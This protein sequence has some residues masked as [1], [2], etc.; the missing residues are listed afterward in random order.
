MSDSKHDTQMLI[1]YEKTCLNTSLTVFRLPD[2]PQRCGIVFLH[3]AY[4]PSDMSPRFAFAF[5]PNLF[6]FLLYC[7]CAHPYPFSSHAH[8]L[9]SHLTHISS[10]HSSPYSFPLFFSLFSRTSP[11]P[12][13]SSL[14]PPSSIRFTI[15]CA[16]RL[17]P[18]IVRLEVNHRHIG[19]EALCPYY[20]NL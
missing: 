13:S 7:S 11:A 16:L 4:Q 14:T 8:S 20:L 9:N 6:L 3:L 2:F 15:G 12:F 5:L 1:L 18:P 10:Q 17:L 19:K